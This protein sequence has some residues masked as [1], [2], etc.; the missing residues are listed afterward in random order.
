M[1][2]LEEKGVLIIENNVKIEIKD[3]ICLAKGNILVEEDI[4][5]YKEVEESEWRIIEEDELNG[6][7][8]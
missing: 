1:E 4:I 6:G 3:G 8:D 5:E 7:S 2:S